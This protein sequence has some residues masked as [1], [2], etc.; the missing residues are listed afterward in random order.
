MFAAD[1]FMASTRVP[2]TSCGLASAAP[3][4]LSH[5]TRAASADFSQRAGQGRTRHNRRKA[6]W[7]GS[8]WAWADTSCQRVTAN[9]ATR[10]ETPSRWETPRHARNN[11]AHLFPNQ[12]F[13]VRGVGHRCPQSATP[14]RMRG[15]VGHEVR[16]HADA[17]GRQQL[18]GLVQNW[19][20]LR[21]H[22]E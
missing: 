21:L 10:R 1:T 6:G 2:D 22:D 19:H 13:E 5:A 7:A 17:E 15:G 18:L 14:P 11:P 8:N 9:A 20:V 12:V 4:P 16:N 3:H